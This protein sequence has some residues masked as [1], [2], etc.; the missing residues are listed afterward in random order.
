MVGSRQA[1]AQLVADLAER[2][3]CRAPGTVGH[4]AI[5]YRRHPEPE[6]RRIR[7]PEAAL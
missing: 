5:L 3:G 1:T 2:T 7:L 6:R 4:V